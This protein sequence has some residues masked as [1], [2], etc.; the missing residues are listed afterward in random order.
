MTDIYIIYHVAIIGEWEQIVKEQL[1]SLEHSGLGQASSAIY[2]QLVGVSGRHEFEKLQKR[3]ATYS[4]S[5][6]MNFKFY[7]NLEV[8]EYPSVNQVQQ[9]ARAHPRAKLFY[10]HTKGAS[11][12]ELPKEDS[13]AYRQSWTPKQV[14]NLKQWRKFMEYYTITKWQ[15]CC[16]LLDYYD[17]CGTDWVKAPYSDNFYFSGN[18][19]WATSAYILRCN[20][21][22]GNRFDCE[23]FIGTGSPRAKELM[24]S[25]HNPKLKRYLSDAEILERR[26]IGGVDPN[27]PIF[28]WW[29]YFYDDKYFKS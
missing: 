8:F 20:L 6:K 17:C 2:I 3:F 25:A 23:N 10:F 5:A 24:S 19:W 7:R 9:L 13:L 16:K 15:D 26:Y 4:F 1:K 11:H 21:N 29:N 27:Y 18:F 12:S 14:E 22:K 28:Q